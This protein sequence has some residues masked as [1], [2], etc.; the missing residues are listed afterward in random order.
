MLSQGETVAKNIN[1]EQLIQKACHLFRV[2]GYCSTSIADI[3]AACQLSK[4]SIYYHVPSKS[5]LLLMVVSHFHQ[6][7][8]ENIFNIAYDEGLPMEQRLGVFVKALEDF[9]INSEG[10]CLMSN[11]VVEADAI[12]SEVVHCVDNYFQDLLKALCHLLLPIYQDKADR[13]ARTFV[14]QFQGSIL[15]KRVFADDAFFRDA[16]QDFLALLR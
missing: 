14:A 8:R 2:K 12:G 11:L 13:V 6:Y 7:C 16:I 4:A 3:A 15:L 10:G 1:K 5:A 9:Y